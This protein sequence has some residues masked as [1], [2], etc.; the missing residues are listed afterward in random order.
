MRKAKERE[1]GR[2][3][4]GDARLGGN[5]ESF[6]TLSPRTP[7][8]D[9]AWSAYTD[10]TRRVR[11]RKRPPMGRSG[12]RRYS[13]WRQ[14]RVAVRNRRGVLRRRHRGY[15]PP[16]PPWGRAMHSYVYVCVCVYVYALAYTQCASIVFVHSC[17][18]GYVFVW[19]RKRERENEIH[20]L[21]HIPPLPA[22][23]CCCS[24]VG[25]RGHR[26][27]YP[28]PPRTV[29]PRIILKCFSTSRFGEYPR[30]SWSFQFLF[31]ILD[32]RHLPLL[33]S[34]L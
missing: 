12:W 31:I 14:P 4:R 16:F 27:R 34:T 32:D 1:R 3:G 2:E 30:V 23:S 7:R 13:G 8:T 9:P 5:F 29:A 10:S 24:C 11:D 21:P 19:K 6:E 33:Q 22:R 15:E 26:S 20:L 18:Y 17:G 28:P 25:F